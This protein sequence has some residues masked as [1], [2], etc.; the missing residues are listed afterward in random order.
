M[1]VSTAAAPAGGGHHGR[2]RFPS[3]A[4]STQG[5]RIIR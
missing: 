3:T 2:R 1:T 4:A 5:E